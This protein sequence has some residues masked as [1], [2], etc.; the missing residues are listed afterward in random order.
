MIHH[1]EPVRAILDVDMFLVVFLESIR[2]TV[3]PDS[4]QAGQ[5]LREMSVH[6]G[7]QDII[8]TLELVSEGLSDLW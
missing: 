1:C 4:G 2:F 7:P 6:R 8:E 5:A 3:S